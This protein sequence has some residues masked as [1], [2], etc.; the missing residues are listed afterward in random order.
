MK[1]GRYGI[2]IIAA[3]IILA[4]LL[5]IV[6]PKL[7]EKRPEK[8]PAASDAG[9]QA[10]ITAKGV[11][12]S[13]ED[14]ELSS[15]LKGTITRVPVEEGAQVHKGQLLLE[16]DQSKIDAQRR[17]ARSALAAAESRYRE[18][19]AGYRSEDILVAQGG[20]ERAAAI[21]DQAR[22]SYERQQRL[23]EKGAAT[24]VDLNR[25]MERLK[26][27]EG[28]L[29]GAAANL[30]KNRQGVRGEERD[31]AHADLERARADLQYIDSVSRDYQVYA[32]ISG[33]I[34]ERQKNRGEGV[35][36][37]SPLFR[38]INPETFRI[39]AELEET[40]IGR[41]TEGQQ[42]EVTVEAF[43]NKVFRGKVSKVFPVVHKKSQK[44]FDPMA[45]FDIN[46][47]KI[48][49]RLDEYTGLRNGMTSTVR[50][51]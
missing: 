28:D 21:Y 17:Q 45:S 51:M 12:E 19:V 48:F 2:T 14:V 27:A 31:Q 22:D 13:A 49:I 39:R 33:I 46:T 35:D 34:T 15:Q 24:Q 29:S 30:K 20:K 18:A 26:I 8:L 11:V 25:A 23:F 10:G 41:V 40:D 5:A 4:A 42:V 36:I 44:S 47:Q 7:V 6:G 50:F 38:I 37:G 32:P 9:T 43:R 16:F 3:L 1:S